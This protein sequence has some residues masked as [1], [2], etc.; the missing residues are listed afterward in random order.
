[1]DLQVIHIFI[2]INN[3]FIYKFI[4]KYANYLD[5]WS[6]IYKFIFVSYLDKKLFIYLD[7]FWIISIYKIIHLYMVKNKL[8]MTIIDSTEMFFKKFQ[9]RWHVKAI[10]FPNEN[11]SRNENVSKIRTQNF[12]N[13]FLQNS[14]LSQQTSKITWNV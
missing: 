12:L 9:K 2:Q 5:E 13:F 1:M 7:D 4:E 6:F 10:T 14:Q 11:V 8:I 3:I